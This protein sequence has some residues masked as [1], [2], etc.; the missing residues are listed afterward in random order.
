[1]IRNNMRAA[2][3]IVIGLF[4]AMDTA[5]GQTLDKSNTL[6]WIMIESPEMKKQFLI[7]FAEKLGEQY[8]RLRFSALSKCLED[9]AD[10]P[11]NWPK[12]IQPFA[13]ECAAK[14]G[15]R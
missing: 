6:G 8:P 14:L 3:T 15:A 2:A 12:D 13:S 1:M 4:G 10:L 7:G 9:V 11:V 5:E